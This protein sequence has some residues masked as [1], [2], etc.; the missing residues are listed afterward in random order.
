MTSSI[1]T[2]SKV[3]NLHFCS[4]G[5]GNAA[6]PHSKLHHTANKQV[7]HKKPQGFRLASVCE[8]H[9]LSII[10]EVDD[11]NI[12]IKAHMLTMYT[13]PLLDG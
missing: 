3:T 7:A 6:S 10:C 11:H 4:C 8:V 9:D 1:G 13:L 5:L 12:V 2:Q